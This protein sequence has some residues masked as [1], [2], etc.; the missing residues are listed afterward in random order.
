MS[1]SVPTDPQHHHLMLFSPQDDGFL[2]KEGCANI[3]ISLPRPQDF[4]PNG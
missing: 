3:Q 2:G 1:C 4:A